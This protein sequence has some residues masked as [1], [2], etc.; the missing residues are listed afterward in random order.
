MTLLQILA[1]KQDR[2]TFHSPPSDFKKQ[3]IWDKKN[4][5]KEFKYF[6]HI[7]CAFKMLLTKSESLKSF[8]SEASKPDWKIHWNRNGGKNKAFLK[9]LK[10]MGSE[11]SCP[12][13]VSANAWYCIYVQIM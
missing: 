13:P 12:S 7:L 2:S 6:P 9:I 11:N 3:T 1:A 8:V 5:K 10:A 4:F